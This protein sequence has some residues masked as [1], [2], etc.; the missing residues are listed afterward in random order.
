M[1]KKLIGKRV[2]FTYE[3]SKISSESEIKPKVTREYGTVYNGTGNLLL[4]P[5]FLC[6]CNKVFL[7][8]HILKLAKLSKVAYLNLTFSI[9]TSAENVTE[10][11]VSE[12]LVEVRRQAARTNE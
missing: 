2:C 1:R 7:D 8:V 3:K 6:F 12:G 11:L 4:I 5:I 9:D 10:S